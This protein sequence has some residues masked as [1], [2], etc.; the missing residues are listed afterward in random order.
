MSTDSTMAEGANSAGSSVGG[1]FA[2]RLAR[3]RPTSPADWF[4]WAVAWF[5][6]V[7]LGAQVAYAFWDNTRIDWWPAYDTNAYWL[8]ARHLLDGS[9]L[10]QQSLIWS[11]GIY[12]YPPVLAQL[13]I[14]IALVPE[15]VI[16]WALRI[17]GILCVRYLAGSW[18]F[19]IVAML[20]WPIFAELSYGNITLQLGAV[21]L[22][23]FGR[24]RAATAGMLLLPWFAAMKVGP[25]LLIPWLWFVRPETRRT[26]AIGV[27]IFA[28]ACLVSLAI[29]PGLWFDYLGTFA[30]EASSEMRAMWVFAIVP[31]HGGLDF[32]ARLLIALVLLLVAIRWR[33][34][35]LAF[36]VAAATMPIFSLTRLAILVG[37]WPLWL[38]GVVERWRAG[39][40]ATAA[41]VTAPLVHLHMVS[42][43]PAT[44]S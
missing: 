26:L 29:A 22:A 33:L 31:A 1:S 8:A 24:G 5:L 12:K 32:A 27:G 9:P 2:D 11:S 7:V 6:I 20:Q 15:P 10:Y 13:V 39:G 21:L 34:G 23:C 44:E 42:R 35:W 41:W 43:E 40:S 28:A 38:R 25:G 37:L 4:G 3:L 17:L 18:R 16:D 30:W 14:P 19:A 36:A